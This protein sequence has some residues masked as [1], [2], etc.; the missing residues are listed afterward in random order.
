MNVGP[1]VV[2]NGVKV[3]LDYSLNCATD[4]VTYVYLCKLCEDPCKDGFY[5]GQTI[6]CMRECTN[7]HC[8]CFHNDSYMKSVL[9][10]HIWEKHRDHFKYKLDNFREGV[11]KS[12][13]PANL[14]RAEDFFVHVTRADTMGLN[15][16]KVMA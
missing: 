7:G 16:Y 9:A 11:I 4:C 6:N 15:R 3:K 10:F 1:Y 13:M 12:V 2:V 8:A 14:D 5:F